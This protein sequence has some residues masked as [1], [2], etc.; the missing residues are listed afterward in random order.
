MGKLTD[1][2]IKA[3][4]R[5]GKPIA[6]KSDGD[7]LTFTR[8]DAGTNS[9]VLRYRYGGKAKECTIGN[10]PDMGI[11]EAR[12][13]AALLRAKV[14]RGIDVA[15]EKRK[16]KLA[17]R[18]AQSVENLAQQ[19]L[20]LAGPK[21]KESTQK[22]VARYIGKDILPRIG[23][24]PA[25]EITAREIVYVVEQVAK[26]SHSVARRTFETLSVIFSFGVARHAVPRNP[27]ADL[28][29]SAIIGEAKPRRP[30]VNLSEEELRIILPIAQ[31]LGKENALAIKILLATC[32]RKSELIKAKWQD[33]DNGLWTIPAENAKNKKA[34]VIPLA[35]T[36]S[37][38]FDELRTFA[39]NSKFVLPARKN[40]Y[41]KKRD[42]ISKSTLNSAL[43]RIQ[44]GVRDFSPHDL[45][46]TARSHLAAMGVNIIV[47]E[48]CLNHDLGGLISVYDKHD[49]L[50]ERRRVLE[51]WATF[52]QDCE[53]GKQSDRSNVVSL[54]CIA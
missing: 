37:G 18:S 22:E 2:Q 48:R 4:V 50:D 38:W 46:S 40:G 52:L 14:D 28:K 26:R 35:P 29:V 9:W 47:A 25:V 15:S 6:G 19:Y 51:T 16:E 44:L 53:T 20:E 11:S 39:E 41:G 13:E 8:S 31:E 36:V 21:L 5:S 32:S 43:D 49:Y 1:L 54:H 45:R 17:Q 10:Y 23:K 12:S 27:C 33:I 24:T 42:T 3:W 34:F 30:R 7:G